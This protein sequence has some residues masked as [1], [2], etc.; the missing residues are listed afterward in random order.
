MMAQ[1]RVFAQMPISSLLCFPETACLEYL[2]VET[3][4]KQLRFVISPNAGAEVDT[5]T[6]LGENGVEFFAGR[7][8]GDQTK[9]LKLAFEPIRA[10]VLLFLDPSDIFVA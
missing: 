4:Q 8:E 7:T 9:T 5:V 2:P 1:C 10:R 6:R 3:K